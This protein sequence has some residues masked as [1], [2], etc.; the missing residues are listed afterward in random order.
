MIRDA[1]KNMEISYFH[2]TEWLGQPGSVLGDMICEKKF[3]KKLIL[4]P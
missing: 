1:E 4:F 2:V 3:M